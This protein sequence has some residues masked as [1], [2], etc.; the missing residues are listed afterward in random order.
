MA[1]NSETLKLQAPQGSS[2]S[3][4]RVLMLTGMVAAVVGGGY[5]AV[6]QM[7]GPREKVKFTGVVTYQGKPV[8]VGSVMTEVVGDP[9]D[10]SIGFLDAEGRFSL[11]TN[12]EPGASVGRHRVRISSM[13][14][15][16]P[17]RPLVPPKYL[18]SAT[19]PLEIEVTTD[20]KANVVTFELE[21]EIPQPASAG[22]PPAGP[23]GA[24]GAP[25]APGPESSAPAEGAAEASPATE[26]TEGATPNPASQAPAEASPA[27][28]SDTGA[29][30]SPQ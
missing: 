12:G 13:A 24:P 2:F 22:G 18:E 14:P 9:M 6:K 23:P 21:G 10:F 19:T 3:I 5:Y 11:E 17:P 7:Q 20:P 8:T 26:P 27:S 25:G 4:I 29:E 15:G 1:D 30:S 16:I 28:E